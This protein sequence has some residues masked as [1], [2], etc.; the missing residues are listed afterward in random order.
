VSP[1]PAPRITLLDTEEALRRAAAAGVP[2]QVAGLSIF[3][4][5][6]HNPRVAKSFSDLVLT[7]MF[8]AELDP[9]LRELVIMRIAWTTGSCYEWTQHWRI[10]LDLG[11]NEAD[12]LGVRDWQDHA[13]F[14]PAE[15][16]VLHATDELVG[17]GAVGED[18]WQAC[19]AHLTE[20][21]LMELAAS[22]GTWSMV[23]KFLRALDVPLEEGV[24]PWPP[25]GAAPRP[26]ARSAP[27]PPARSAPRPP[28]R[29]APRPPS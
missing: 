24:A 1:D 26:P 7:L 27:R 2:E 3:R 28:T 14:G 23:S 6:L 29:S 20:T 19:A 17:T 11:V 16:A 25:D 22:I 5:L 13:G 9:R 4:T 12:L 21:A 18:T 8:R 15:R 10:A